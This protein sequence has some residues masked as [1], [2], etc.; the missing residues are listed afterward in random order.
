MSALHFCWSSVDALPP[1]WSVPGGSAYTLATHAPVVVV[2]GTGSE[3][4]SPMNADV[5]VSISPLYLEISVAPQDATMMVARANSQSPTVL[6]PKFAHDPSAG[7]LEYRSLSV[8]SLSHSFL[9]SK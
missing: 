3:T 1:S 9:C 4:A 6:R 5:P 2:V 7:V 8:L